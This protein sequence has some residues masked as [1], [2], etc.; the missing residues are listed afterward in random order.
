MQKQFYGIDISK[1]KLQIATKSVD[2][3]WQDSQITNE[4]GSIESWLL[5]ISSDNIHL[6]YEYT[7]TYTHRLTYCCELLSINFTIITSKQ[8]KGFA[9]S[10]KMSSKTDKL[11]A[12][13][14]YLY[15][16]QKQP[17]NTAIVDESIHQK[18][19]TYQYFITLKSEKQAFSNRLHALSF[20][21]KMIQ[22]LQDEIVLLQSQI[23]N[24]DEHENQRL[25]ALIT[26]VVGI[27]QASAQAIIVATNGLKEFHSSRAVAK[28]LGVCPSDNDSGTTVK[29]SR[30]IVKSG[31]TFVRTTLYMA[32]W[33][34]KT[35]NNACKDIYTR[36]RA[37]GK[38]HCRCQIKH[39][40]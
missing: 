39:T 32:A 28:F 22:T 9:L 24:I 26:S 20:D 36:L 27:G 17:L 8:S 14:L 25:Q 30:A 31:N 5:S 3:H 13:M 11:D 38:P 6:V 2:G 15:G 1:D 33:S 37:K 12:R 34:A 21:P 40:V 7:G 18:R 16:H 29:G 4:I 35:Y 19:Q 10:E 23:Y